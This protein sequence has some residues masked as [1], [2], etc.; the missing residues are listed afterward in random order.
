MIFFS[1][2]YQ[3]NKR[4]QSETIG[5]I[6]FTGFLI[7][8]V[9]TFGLVAT[10]S[11]VD[12]APPNEPLVSLDA[13][14]SMEA[15]TIGHSGGRSLDTDSVAIR[16]QGGDTETIPLA[17]IYSNETFAPGDDVTVSPTETGSLRVLVI[18]SG[19]Q[20]LLDTEL[21][22]PDGSPGRFE[23]ESLGVTQPGLV[24]GIITNTGE[25]EVTQEITYTLGG[26]VIDSGSLTLAPGASKTRELDV[27]GITP[28]GVD[29][30]VSLASENDTDSILIDHTPAFA[31][32]I[33]AVDGELTPGEQITV[34]Y[35][36]ENVGNVRDSQ[37]ITFTV[38]GDRERTTTATLSPSATTSGSFSYTVTSSDT[39]IENTLSISSDDET[40]DR[41]V[42]ATFDLSDL[43]PSTVTVD[44]DTD[45][46]IVSVTVTNTGN[47]TATKN[48]ATQIDTGDGFEP[49]PDATQRVRLNPDE[50]RQLSYTISSSEIDIE[51]AGEY[52]YRAVTE[53]DTIQGLIDATPG[54]GA[55][56]TLIALVLFIVLRKRR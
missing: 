26:T 24:T 18:D 7:I 45:F 52:D 50:Q 13:T 16:V 5:T 11:Y 12:D 44:Q 42:S 34:D 3:M 36:V 33:D 43:S 20:V 56:A 29:T 28:R 21:F 10:V 4:G 14:A 40:A 25:E 22:V 38:D 19:T 41:R 6:L 32:R 17:A 54:F 15:F 53:D 47:I 9:T 55:I 27:S 1:N 2:R 23:I 39:A 49:I 48:V 37:P 8:S 46:V 35:T 51:V 30:T 31:V